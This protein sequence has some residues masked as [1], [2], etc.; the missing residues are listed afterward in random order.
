MSDE[1]FGEAK[2]DTQ[3]RQLKVKWPLRALNLVESNLYGAMCEAMVLE[4]S[5][6]PFVFLEDD[7]FAN[8]E[9]WTALYGPMTAHEAIARR[10]I[11][12]GEVGEKFRRQL[13]VARELGEKAT[14]ELYLIACEVEGIDPILKRKTQ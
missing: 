1:I 4:E 7:Q 9:E 5:R 3:E 11:V 8:E 6:A 2:E 13:I 14:L 12:F 10:D